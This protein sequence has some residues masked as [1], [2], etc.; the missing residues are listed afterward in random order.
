VDP[1]SPD[2]Q[3]PQPAGRR[4]RVSWIVGFLLGFAI[5]MFRAHPDVVLA[6][7][8]EIETVLQLK[9][10]PVP[11]SPPKFSPELAG[12]VDAMT[13]Q[14]Q[15]ELLLDE[16]INHYAGAIEMIEPRLERW[17]GNLQLTPKLSQI[18]STAMNSNDL[19]VRAAALET[20]IAA[21]NVEKSTNG[22][23]TLEDRIGAQPEA[24][25]WALWML[26]AL[27]NRGVEP[28]GVLRE[29][30]N[31]IHDSNEQTRMWAVEGLAILGT[32]DALEPLLDSFKNDPSPR[33]RERAA[34]GL[35]QSGMFTE[36]Q[37]M[38][39]VPRLLDMAEDTGLDG[40]TRTWVFHA[41]QDITGASQGSDAQA[42]RRWWNERGANGRR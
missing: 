9:S 7:V 16:S 39:I 10:T 40:Q 34:C 33:V 32:D 3:Q 20:Y 37:R 22:V 42:W 5:V 31:Y 17:H 27:G 35:A 30:L 26:G 19:R 15:A 28:V 38:S 29:E 4:I 24:R 6:A 21:Y 13:P 41:L 36:P 14:G 25:P 11:A 23:S 1:Y 8:D 12:Q 18:L 2:L